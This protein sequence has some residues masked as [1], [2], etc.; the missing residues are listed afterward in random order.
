MKTKIFRLTRR[1]EGAVRSPLQFIND[2]LACRIH[3]HPP[4][5]YNGF[6]SSSTIYNSEPHVLFWNHFL[7]REG[8]HIQ[9][10]RGQS[11]AGKSSKP[12]ESI[13]TPPL[14]YNGF[15]S[16]STIYNSK[17]QPLF[18]F[19]CWHN[20]IWQRTLLRVQSYAGKPV[21][22][23]LTHISYWFHSLRSIFKSEPFRTKS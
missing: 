21:E 4:L 11:H 9:L 7:S 3:F 8:G 23:I 14:I 19:Y 5:I 18:H 15:Q 20:F 1:E 16:S 6:Q 17:S 13:F 22:S 10:L 12:V 2:R